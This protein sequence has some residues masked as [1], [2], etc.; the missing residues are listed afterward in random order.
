MKKLLSLFCVIIAVGLFAFIP[1]TSGTLPKGSIIAWGA[2]TGIP[3]G[4][5][6][7]NGA[8]G[9]PDLVGRFPYGTA[10]SAEIGQ[11][12]GNATHKHTVTGDTGI[13]NKPMNFN[14]DE[15]AL[16][17]DGGQRVH[18]THKITGE[19]SEESLIPPSTKVV[20]IMKIR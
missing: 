11:K 3:S 2:K 19:T 16:Q 8:N 14:G 17:K 13:P 1:S 6:V 12:I 9:T 15:S 10:N 4:W 18:H 5:V 20:F 7:C